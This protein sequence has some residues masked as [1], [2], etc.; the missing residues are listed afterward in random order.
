M[1]D[2]GDWSDDSDK[3]TPLPPH[4]AE[5]ARAASAEV[6]DTGGDFDVASSIFGRP[7][8]KK[9]GKQAITGQMRMSSPLP[10]D[11]VHVDNSVVVRYSVTNDPGPGFLPGPLDILVPLPP[12]LPPS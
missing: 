1:S 3:G 10:C 8:T 9:K 4:L 5:F 7:S 2:T 11:T 12:T 6:M